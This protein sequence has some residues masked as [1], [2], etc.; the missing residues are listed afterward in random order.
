MAFGKAGASEKIAGQ[1]PRH[2]P[3]AVIL[4]LN[5]AL[6]RSVFSRKFYQEVTDKVLS[7]PAT[8]DANLYFICYSTL[9]ASTVLN[10][11]PKIRA[12][13]R[14]QRYKLSLVI[15][16][17]F[18]R[19]M[20]TSLAESDNKWISRAFAEP[21][22]E[23]DDQSKD[24]QEPVSRLAVHLK[25][26]S[27]YLSDVRIFNRLFD[28]IKYIP[29]VID[30]YLALVNP[31][32]PTPIVDRIVNLSQALNCLVLELLENVGWLTDHN[33]IGTADNTYWCY[34]TYVWCSRIWGLYILLEIAE[35][36]RKVPFSKWDRNWKISMFKQLTLLPLAVHWSLYEGCLSPFWVGLLGSGTSWFNFINVWKTL[37]L[38]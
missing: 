8:I 28:S 24:K 2:V 10:N 32:S 29:W 37:N 6:R 31:A 26:V 38:D 1:I 22:P 20:G 16:S 5:S 34:L 23:S 4:K 19:A 25:A 9:L 33:W 30:E 21:R 11:K 15:D 13:L 12:F 36:V 18:K 35:L 14:Q 7:L 17:V 27:S 3:L